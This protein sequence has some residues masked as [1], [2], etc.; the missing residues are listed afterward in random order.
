M[1]QQKRAHRIAFLSCISFL[2][3]R[4]SEQACEVRVLANQRLIPKKIRFKL[5]E[6]DAVVVEKQM[7]VGMICDG[8][9][10]F[11]PC[12]DKLP[13]LLA[14]HSLAGYEQHSFDPVLGKRA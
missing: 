8:V 6:R 14:V 3:K 10:I 5:S 11:V 2:E 7:R 9:A 13:S 1:L 4:K 12:C